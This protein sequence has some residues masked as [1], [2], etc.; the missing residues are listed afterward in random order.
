MSKREW[1]MEAAKEIEDIDLTGLRLE[2]A[3]EA[4]TRV[5]NSFLEQAAADG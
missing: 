3:E 4:A 1:I 2:A 5:I